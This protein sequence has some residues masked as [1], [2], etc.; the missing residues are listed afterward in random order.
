MAAVPRAPHRHSPLIPLS[1]FPLVYSFVDYLP[2][3]RMPVIWIMYLFAA[4]EVW[5]RFRRGT[6]PPDRATPAPNVS[7]PT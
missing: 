4:A 7:R 5:H 6:A 3:F 1:T 2:R